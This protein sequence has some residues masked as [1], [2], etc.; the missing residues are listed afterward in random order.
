MFNEDVLPE[1]IEAHPG[2]ESRIVDQEHLE[3][4]I[5]IKI[6]NGKVGKLFK[7]KINFNDINQS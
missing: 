1:L 7:I 4:P 6:I 2:V 5:Q 3:K